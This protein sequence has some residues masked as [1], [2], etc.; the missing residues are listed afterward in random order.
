MSARLYMVYTYL[1][2]Q[3]RLRVAEIGVGENYTVEDVIR[4]K[5][6]FHSLKC[7]ELDGIRRVG[8][9]NELSNSFDGLLKRYTKLNCMVFNIDFPFSADLQQETSMSNRF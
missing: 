8:S 6:I 7:G 4:L 5:E 3:R 1:E 2:Y 9:T